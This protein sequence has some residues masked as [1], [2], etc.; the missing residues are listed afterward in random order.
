[1][2][3]LKGNQ[4]YNKNTILSLRKK[5]DVIDFEKGMNSI[6]VEE[7]NFINFLSSDGSNAY[8]IIEGYYIESLTG[9][10]SFL[11]KDFKFEGYTNKNTFKNEKIKAL[12]QKTSNTIFED[13]DLIDLI[14]YKNKTEKGIQ[15]FIK[16]DSESAKGIVYLIDLYH[17]V[18]PTDKVTKNYTVKSNPQKEYQRRKKK[19]KHNVNLSDIIQKKA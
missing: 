12:I 14:K 17:L 7:H 5:T 1:M 13:E 19:V 3:T 4:L 11:D 2:S 9:N 15:L 6:D 10:Y 18:I 8:Q 16:Y